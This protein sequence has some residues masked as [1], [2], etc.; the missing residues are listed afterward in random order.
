M[1]TEAIPASPVPL[2]ADQAEAMV[3]R[4]LN[5]H[6]VAIARL[7]WSNAATWILEVAA[8]AALIV[9]PYFRIAPQ[10]YT[11]L[12]EGILGG[13]RERGRP[14]N[15]RAASPRATGIG[16]SDGVMAGIAIWGRMARV[17]ARRRNA[18]E[19]LSLARP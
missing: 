19:S 2:S 12:V 17:P 6:D 8:G 10:W 7:H 18:A 15:R 4:R 1:S 5:E 14:G 16:G 3:Q 13:R 11:A 9:L